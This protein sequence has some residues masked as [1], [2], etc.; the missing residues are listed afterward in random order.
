MKPKLHCVGFGNFISL[1]HLNLVLSF[2]VMFETPKILA[3]LGQLPLKFSIMG[4][5]KTKEMQKFPR[6]FFRVDQRGP[7]SKKK[8]HLL[9]DKSSCKTGKGSEFVTQRAITLVVKKYWWGNEKRKNFVNLGKKIW[10]GDV[11]ELGKGVKRSCLF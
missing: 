2:P 5:Q 9:P 7:G 6:V 1:F 10:K 8:Q 11:A 3:F 4:Y